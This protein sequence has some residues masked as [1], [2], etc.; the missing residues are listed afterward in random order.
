M[1]ISNSLSSKKMLFPK[2]RYVG[3]TLPEVLISLTIVGFLAAGLTFF[4]TDVSRGL[5]WGAQKIE[6]SQDVRSFTM[7]IA[8]EARSANSAIIYPSF[9]ATDRDSGVDRRD[10]GLSGDCL[11]LVNTE[12]FPDTDS[13]EHYTR[14]IVYF[15]KADATDNVGPV[16]RIEWPSSGTTGTGHYIDA[17]TKTIEAQLASIAPNDSGDYPVIVELSRGMADGRLFTNFRQGKVIVVNGEI[18]HGNQAEEV[19]N[20]YNLS[21]SP[22][23]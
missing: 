9:S 13:P 16:R 10:D 6:I 19:T 1:D 17:T 20:T 12:P 22:R 21:I 15:R 14:I 3:F 11:V 2:K 7:R 8:A 23:G 4:M 5:F 18:L